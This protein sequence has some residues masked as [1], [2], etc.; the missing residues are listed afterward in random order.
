MTKR[1]LSMKKMK[2]LLA[3]AKIQFTSL[4]NKMNKTWLIFC[5]TKTKLTKN[6]TNFCHPKPRPPSPHVFLRL[7]HSSKPKPETLLY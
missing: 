5:L 2:L 4:V 3:L 7:T 6:I 1:Q